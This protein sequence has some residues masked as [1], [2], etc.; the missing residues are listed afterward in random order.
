[1]TGSVKP[2]HV[3]R[4]LGA[5]RQQ[6]RPFLSPGEIGRIERSLVMLY[7]IEAPCL[8]SN[9]KQRLPYVAAHEIP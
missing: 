8:R 6:N 5:C 2:S 4:K 3:L 7:W 9:A 1:M